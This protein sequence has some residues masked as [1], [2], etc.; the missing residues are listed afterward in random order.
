LFG[1]GDGADASVEDLLQRLS[2]VEY[3]RAA[4]SKFECPKCNARLRREWDDYERLAKLG[5]V[6]L[7]M[8]NGVKEEF[9]TLK[10][11]AVQR[12]LFF[13]L[14]EHLVISVKR[15]GVQDKFRTKRQEPLGFPLQL[16]V[17][18]NMLHRV[19]KDSINKRVYESIPH[20]HVEE[21]YERK[22]EPKFAYKLYAVIT[23]I[24]EIDAGHYVT[25]CRYE[26]F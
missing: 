9:A 4:E 12:T 17:D 24:G 10:T 26:T 23:H 25:F 18:E 22:Y 14:P 11:E 16:H 2:Q 1:K 8:K 6:E 20:S 15:Y 5:Q 21:S 13:D 3:L 19:H 7:K